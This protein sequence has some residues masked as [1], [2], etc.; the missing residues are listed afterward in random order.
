MSSQL[1]ISIFE[2]NRIFTWGNSYFELYN[3]ELNVYV[4]LSLCVCICAR[5][6]ILIYIRLLSFFFD[7]SI[8]VRSFNSSYTAVV[9]KKK[10]KK[11]TNKVV[12]YNTNSVYA[13]I[14]FLP[15]TT[16]FLFRGS[17]FFS[18]LFFACRIF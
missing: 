16:S 9:E 10:E 5:S 14:F 15:S 2:R 8:A 4:R 13:C 3:H 1:F 6:Y 17:V 7:I 12:K 11:K 18:P